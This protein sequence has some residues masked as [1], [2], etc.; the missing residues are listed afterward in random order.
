MLV[1]V[2]VQQIKA[3]VFDRLA[4]DSAGSAVRAA[5]LAANSSVAAVD[6]IVDAAKLSTVRPA[7][8]FLALRRGP[9][10]TIEDSI[11]AATF[12]WFIYDD[13]DNTYF[14]SNSL[15]LLIT[16]AYNYETY[17][18]THNSARLGRVDMLIGEE[19]VDTKL[20]NLLVTKLTLTV[21]C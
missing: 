5:L 7:A 9:A 6:R 4:V 12:Y 11:V 1:A 18:L 10:P 13:P 16:R 3:V 8:P 20:G 15:V 2:D 17:P 14:D 19:T 21:Y